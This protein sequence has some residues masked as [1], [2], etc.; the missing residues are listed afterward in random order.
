MIAGMDYGDVISALVSWAETRTQPAP[1]GSA[2]SISS[3]KPVATFYAEVMAA[4]RELD[5][6]VD[7]SVR[8]IEVE[9][10]IP[11]AQDTEHAPTTAITLMRSGAS[12]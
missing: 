5:I 9:R 1:T 11:F 12:W 10:S 6:D 2:G 7:I 3:P 8:P 4:L